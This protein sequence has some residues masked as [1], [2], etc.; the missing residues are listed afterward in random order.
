[1]R[2]KHLSTDLGLLLVLA[3][4]G[5]GG[6]SNDSVASDPGAPDNA[7]WTK[8]PVV[9]APNAGQ[10]NRFGFRVALSADGNTLAISAPQER[11]AALGVN[12][13]QQQEQGA[14]RGAVYLFSRSGSQDWIF[15][16]YIKASVLLRG[17]FA[18]AFGSAISLSADGNTL[19]VGARTANGTR[20]GIGET[21][22]I[23]SGALFVFTRTD[24]QTWHETAILRA[25]NG[26]TLDRLGSSVTISA[27]GKT[28]VAGA[29]TRD[30]GTVTGEPDAAQR[31]RDSGAAY[32]FSLDES[33]RWQQTAL[34]RAPEPAVNDQ[35]GHS[36]VVSGDGNRVVVGA[37]RESSGGSGV[38]E[39]RLPGTPDSERTG[40]AYIFRR[41]GDGYSLEAMLKPQQP[42]RYQAFGQSLAIDD[43][44]SRLAVGGDFTGYAEQTG[45]G[46]IDYPPGYVDI[47]NR[48]LLAWQ[49]GGVL[50]DPRP[51][52]QSDRFGES[53]AITPDGRTLAVGMSGDQLELPSPVLYRP[54]GAV[55]VFV[56]DGQWQ[57]TAKITP[58]D[59]DSNAQDM[60]RSVAISADG[61]LIIAGASEADGAAGGRSLTD[62][63]RVYPLSLR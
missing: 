57:H 49:P 50:A 41:Q 17:E 59:D 55:H 44:G 35:F 37:P 51:R 6:G 22:R 32:V 12:A 62:S 10:T 29:P 2:R 24:G 20:D 36:V 47:Y 5:G 9:V 31:L 14:F 40:A 7:G 60:G 26:L 52:A 54:R 28:I 21:S 13:S 8:D 61:R 45:S 34:L 46:L 25:D 19:V 58:A 23:E 38:V 43:A 11:S 53:L 48:N 30:Y 1:M 39:Q 18:P 16:T 27:D 15:Q 3:G 33:G 63:G 42:Q 56:N 4:C